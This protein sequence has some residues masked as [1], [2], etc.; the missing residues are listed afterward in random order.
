[1]FGS[2]PASPWSEW[3]APVL[4]N[5]LY[6]VRRE[7]AHLRVPRT[8]YLVEVLVLVFILTHVFRREGDSPIHC[9]ARTPFDG[10]MIHSSHVILIHAMIHS[11]MLIVLFYSVYRF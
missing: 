7:V 3:K 9:D 8:R 11:S 4:P 2:D 6:R 10:R 5:R 1:M